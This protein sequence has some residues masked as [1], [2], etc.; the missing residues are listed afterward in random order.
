M[1]ELPIEMDM[2]P[3][4][5]KHLTGTSEVNNETAAHQLISISQDSKKRFMLFV[6]CVILSESLNVLIQY[7][8]LGETMVSRI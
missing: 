7:Q 3:L 2:G 8:C 5:C 6:F 1:L 4:S